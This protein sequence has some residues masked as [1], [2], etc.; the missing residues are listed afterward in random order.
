MNFSEY[1]R[2]EGQLLG[3]RGTVAKQLQLKFGPLPAEL[4]VRLEYASQ[5]ELDRW[6]EV[7]LSAA[8]L[9]EIFS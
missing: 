3:Q 4:A 1:A 7:V 8:T 6:T 2:Q 5:Q 9:D